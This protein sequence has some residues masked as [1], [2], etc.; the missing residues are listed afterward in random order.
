MRKFL[1][2]FLIL[3][4]VLYF[5]VGWFAYGQAAAVPCEVWIEE[6]KNTPSSWT[7]GEKADWNPADYF[8]DNYEEVT[9]YADNGEIELA[10][11]WV[12]NDLSNPSLSEI[13]LHSLRYSLVFT[14]SSPFDFLIEFKAVLRNEELAIPAISTGY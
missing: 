3:L 11:W 5:G 8:I 12:E 9:I 6:S 1:R 13:S 14:G 4:V 10:S 7:L 2:F